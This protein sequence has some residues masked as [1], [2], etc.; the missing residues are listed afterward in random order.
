[1]DVA[2]RVSAV[3]AGSSGELRDLR[4]AWRCAKFADAS[5]CLRRCAPAESPAV[6]ACAYADQRP[7]RRLGRLGHRLFAICALRDDD[8]ERRVVAARNGW[9]IGPRC[10]LAR[11][12]TS[13]PAPVTPGPARRPPP[14]FVRRLLHR[15]G[16]PRLPAPLARRPGHVARPGP[17]PAPHAVPPLPRRHTSRVTKPVVWS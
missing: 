8:T 7:R 3:A 1:M 5:Y 13:C 6:A 4:G 11:A 15:P 9:V 17:G 12:A 10:A 2:Q 14:A 16:R